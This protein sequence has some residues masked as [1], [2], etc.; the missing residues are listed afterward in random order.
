MK[1]RQMKAMTSTALPIQKLIPCF[2]LFNVSTSIQSLHYGGYFAPHYPVH[3]PV[4]SDAGPRQMPGIRI[5]P[6]KASGLKDNRR[7]L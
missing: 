7:G 5:I 3:G 6:L 2:E 4:V 1:N